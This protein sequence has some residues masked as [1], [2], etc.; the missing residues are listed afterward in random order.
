MGSREEL[1]Q[2]IK[3]SGTLPED[4]LETEYANDIEFCKE[5]CKTNTILFSF[6]PISMQKE[7]ILQDGNYLSMAD[8]E[9]FDD[10][11]F[12]NDVVSKNHDVLLITAVSQNVYGNEYI[13]NL[14]TGYLNG[15]LIPAK[16][17]RLE[18]AGIV[19]IYKRATQDVRN[20]EELLRS[21]MEE[22]PEVFRFTTGKL[23]NNK[24]IA[25]SAIRLENKNFSY[26][27][28][29]IQA[30][31][32]NALIYLRENPQMFS[33]YG[34]PIFDK[35]DDGMINLVLKA[36]IN[37]YKYLQG[38]SLETETMRKFDSSVQRIQG[39]RPEFTLNNP[40]L[41]Y[42]L[43]LDE[44]FINMNPEIINSL[45]EYDT[46]SIDTLIKLSHNGKLESVL[47]YIENYRTAYGNDMTSI[48]KAIDSFEAVEPTLESV[49]EQNLEMSDPR[50]KMLIDTKNKFG[51][52]DLENFDEKV[53]EY[54]RNKLANVSDITEA[55]NIYS[56][57]LLNRST[58]EVKKF[59]EE[60]CDFRVEGVN[61]YAKENDLEEPIGKE[62]QDRLKL[63]E[64]ISKIE[65]ID[66]LKKSVEELPV[67][68]EN[69]G[70]T[71]S[72]I[73]S[74]YSKIYNSQMLDLSKTS[75]E[76]EKIDGV[77][78]IH[79][80]GQPFQ[81]LIHRLYN[82]DF[83]MTSIANEI[84]ENPEKWNLL[85]G[86]TSI[87]STLIT[88][89]KIAALFGEI[90]KSPYAKLRILDPDVPLE[91]KSEELREIDQNAVFY[92]FT[93]IQDNSIEKMD[94]TDMMVEHGKGKI[95][96]KTSN[97]RFRGPEDLAYWTQDDYWNEVAI[98]RRQTDFDMAGNM[99]KSK[100]Q[101]TC[102]V[103]FDDRINE[104]SMLAAQRHNI[105]V[106]MVDRRKY[107]D[108]NQEILDEKLKDFKETLSTEDL[109]EIFYREKYDKLSQDTVPQI[110]DCIKGNDERSPEEKG[111][112]LAYLRYLSQHFV[113][114]SSG[115][116]GS[117][118]A[119]NYN[120][121]MQDNIVEI[122]SL[123]NK[124]NAKTGNNIET[125]N[126]KSGLGKNQFIPIEEI[127]QFAE[128]ID[129]TEISEVLREIV[130][131]KGRDNKGKGI[132]I[133]NS[134]ACERG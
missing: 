121:I 14:Y 45:L 120:E 26:A 51:M 1:L 124:S 35:M 61:K 104:K 56:E 82:F 43:L 38:S 116:V 53:R 78:V 36:D 95:D 89:K 67:V 70:D 4:F 17:S 40:N 71:E 24:E 74:M 50:V 34:T 48:I 37:N 69:L 83:S 85:E 57:M 102:I 88:D 11:D 109:K 3:N 76:R 75:L 22:N 27:G 21:I 60:Y 94:S 41:R 20:D 92:G 7:L 110:I 39:F 63:L 65:D 6:L 8:Y 122:D 132:N 107:I 113:E 127:K 49:K 33:K 101:P 131:E 81:M 79:L 108:L 111:K 42:E 25:D 87:S 12:I 105:P 30:D 86:T 134:L 114:Q 117:V 118:P 129:R 126:S 72:R 84:I 68:L 99:D 31:P 2:S 62:V 64:Q 100:Q 130:E 73:A 46:G 15:E 18:Q 91:P 29:N 32:E 93:E 98:K 119:E 128:G 58:E 66:E 112:T 55:R 90:K 5:I 106:V 59:V 47:E 44:N 19:E 13:N 103:C 52:M 23:K 115:Y 77:D 96:T 54:Y 125:R 123:I 9:I 97:S 10:Q 133:R 28:K 80:N 16:D